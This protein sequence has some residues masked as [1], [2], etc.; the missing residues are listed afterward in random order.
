MLLGWRA[1]MTDDLADAFRHSGTMHV[2]AIS[3]LHISMITLILV[4]I[5]RA[6]RVP[7]GYCWML[8]LPALW[9][10]AAATGWQASAVRATL[11]SS[12]V[13][14]GW[15]LRRP[16]DLLNT[17]AGAAWLILLWEPGQLFQVGFQ[18]S[19][20]V[21]LGIVLMLPH[22]ERFQNRW[23]VPDPL[24]PDEGRSIWERRLRGAAR[25]VT[26]SLGISLAATLWSVPWMAYYFNICSPVSLVANLAVVPLSA[27]ALMSGLGSLL[28]A[29]WFPYASVLYNHSAWLAMLAMTAA[30]QWSADLPGAWFYVASPSLVVLA[31][32]YLLLTALGADARPYWSR[33]RIAAMVA[34]ALL[35]AG[36][37]LAGWSAAGLRLTVLPLRGGDSLFIDAPGSALDVLV[38]TGDDSATKQVVHPF[39]RARGLNRLPNLVLTHG[40]VRH[41][42]G[43]SAIRKDFQVAQTI[44][45]RVKSR[46][47]AYRALVKELELPGTGW[48]PVERG[49]CVCGWQVLHPAVA[50]HFGRADDN[51]V[52]LLGEFE[53]VRVLLCSDLSR[54]GQRTLLEREPGLRVDVVIS[55]MPNP[56]EPLNDGF[57][58]LL[59][60]RLVVVSAGE[61]PASERPSA[62]L[63]ER[64]CAHRIPVMFTCDHGAVYL[65]LRR[66]QWQARAQD[67]RV[68][69]GRAAAST[70]SAAPAPDAS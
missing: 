20:S 27:I 43:A 38:D 13:L 46:S 51:A 65:T 42:G 35:V 31:G 29:A 21:V 49:D 15:S 28:T 69:S 12:L 52:V 68:E 39:L 30:S 66:N 63:R 62:A 55:G 57:L 2:F 45:S 33:S 9:F 19:F 60:P 32:Y 48:R 11:M 44:T 17:L 47:P 22:L 70:G 64:L 16:Q 67:G 1:G 8:V 3:G 14:A 56:D 26:A 25:E 59:G 50:D 18:L 7:R 53:G 4:A 5:F 37:G 24:V 36:A 54:L 10:Y 6:V 34:G 23:L 61:Y 58:K 40:D 41:V